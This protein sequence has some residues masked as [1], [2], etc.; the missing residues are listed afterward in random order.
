MSFRLRC[1]WKLSKSLV[2]TIKVIANNLFPFNIKPP[3]GTYMPYYGYVH[4]CK[5]K[6][7]VT[8]FVILCYYVWINLVGYILGFS[9]FYC[10]IVFLK[11]SCIETKL[12]LSIFLFNMNVYPIRINH[13]F[14]VQICSPS[15]HSRVMEFF[16]TLNWCQPHLHIVHIVGKYN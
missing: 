15:F 10:I 9:I 8:N 14:Q 16:T 6:F 1:Q 13:I 4:Y 12:E 7:E 11:I 5:L 3:I 2:L